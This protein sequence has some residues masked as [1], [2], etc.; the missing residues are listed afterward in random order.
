MSS[1]S[2]NGYHQATA[3]EGAVPL[4]AE[5]PGAP[6]GPAATQGRKKASQAVRSRRWLR[7]L[8]ADTPLVQRSQ[9]LL[10]Q[11]PAS[12]PAASRE[13]SHEV[14]T[15]AI[16]LADLCKVFATG[17][18]RQ[19]LA[20][21]HLSLEVRQG[22]VFALLGPNGSGK[23]TTVNMIS[24]LLPPS[25]G[26]IRILGMDIRR[27]YLRIR[28]RLGA[29]PQETA[30]YDELTA[31]ANMAFHAD[32]YGVP[33]REKQARIGMLLD[34][35][36]LSD[37]KDSR[38]AT[39]SGGMKRRLAIARALLHDPLLVYLDEPTLGV[40]VQARAAIWEYIRG[41]RRQGKTVLLTTNY[42]EE[43][44]ALCDRLAI[45]DHGRLIAVDTP[46]HLRQ[47]Y[48]GS[49]ITIEVQAQED[50]ELALALEGLRRLAG[51][52]EVTL[53]QRP[54][55]PG[56]GE[57]APGPTGSLLASYAVRVLTR[58]ASNHL[59]QIVNL[60]SQQCEIKDIVIRESN[61]D[62]VFLHLTGSAL[63]D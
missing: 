1:D 21:D 56:G 55:A 36:R 61:L 39:F 46:D 42:L 44:Q 25:S 20:V 51:V 32:L 24:G 34:L 52:H 30:L 7:R 58:G 9:P 18:K 15:P 47:V 45:I 14:V 48:G 22:E 29:V 59:A 50:G 43:A 57:G 40:D 54:A 37:R 3:V 10:L 11:A 2:R 8:L 27:D 23:T 13:L 26:S 12:A 5:R 35:V 63:R 49:V 62:E 31:W 28:Q 38:V 4:I 6:G 53:E 33:Q 41:L 16:A 17:K 60:L 19:V